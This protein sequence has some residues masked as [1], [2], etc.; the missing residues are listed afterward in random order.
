ML[1]RPAAAAEIDH[2]AQLWHD[3]WHESHAPVVP[4]ELTPAS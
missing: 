4:P 1:I 2:L 3:A